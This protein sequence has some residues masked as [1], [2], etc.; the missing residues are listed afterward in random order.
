MLVLGIAM[1]IVH[2]VLVKSVLSQPNFPTEAE[3]RIQ[4][5]FERPRERKVVLMC[6]LFLA[7]YIACTW[8]GCIEII[9]CKINTCRLGFTKSILIFLNSLI[10]P[11]LYFFKD[12]LRR[13]H[14]QRS[15]T[16]DILHDKLP[17]AMKRI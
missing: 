8:P 6:T 9:Q 16:N 2:A 17:T 1:L 5:H 12:Y 13:K 14:K 11:C 7:T 4:F 3:F 10:D 15:K